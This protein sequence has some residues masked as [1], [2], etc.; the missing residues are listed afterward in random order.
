MQADITGLKVRIPAEKEAACLGAAIIAAVSDGR[1]AHF[2][3]AV[4]T[5]VTFSKHTIPTTPCKQ[6][7]SIT[8]FARSTNLSNH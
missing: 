7:K 6:I 8:N 3:K 2:Q 1:Y 4:D 5:L